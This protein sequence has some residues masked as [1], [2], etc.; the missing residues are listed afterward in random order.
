MDLLLKLGI[1]TLFLFI[2][3]YT[4]IGFVVPSKLQACPLAGISVA[5]YVPALTADDVPLIIIF[6]PVIPDCELPLYVTF[7]VEYEASFKT[8]NS[9]KVILALP[10][11]LFWP[12]V[13]DGLVPFQEVTPPI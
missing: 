6:E 5:E 10:V 4:V 13:V 7:D 12:A 9:L 1:V 11:V 2:V 8:P 3:Q